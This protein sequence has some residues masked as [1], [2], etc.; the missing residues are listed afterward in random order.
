[1][2]K[3]NLIERFIHIFLCIFFLL[4]PF[5]FCSDTFATRSRLSGMG[6]LSIVIEDESNMINLWDFAHNPAG[7]LED[8]KRS[9]IRGDFI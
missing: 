4:S 2:P 1:M 5:F 7:F 6:D 9:V 3:V 8:E